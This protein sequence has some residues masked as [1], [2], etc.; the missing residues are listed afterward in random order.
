MVTINFMLRFQVPATVPGGI[1]SDLEKTGF[2]T[3]GNIYFRFNE[4]NYK[5]VAFTN[6]TYKVIIHMSMFSFKVYFICSDLGQDSVYS[7]EMHSE[8]ETMVI[9]YCFLFIHGKNMKVCGK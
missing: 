4:E 3:S 2:L 5:W 6:W 9:H 1:Y 7:N 8:D